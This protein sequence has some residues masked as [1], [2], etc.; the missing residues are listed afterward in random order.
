MVSLFDDS[1]FFSPIPN[2][3][4]L[5]IFQLNC[6]FVDGIDGPP[7]V[8]QGNN[9]SPPPSPP[10]SCVEKVVMVSFPLVFIFPHHSNFFS[11][12]IF[13]LNCYS[14]S[15]A[16]RPPSLIQGN[17]GSPPP[18]LPACCMDKAVMVS[19]PL[20]FIFSPPFQFF[21]SIFSVKL[22][23]SR[24]CQPPSL[25]QSREQWP[26]TTI[27]ARLSRGGSEGGF[28]FC[29]YFFPTIQILSHHFFS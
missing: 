28:S 24:P 7:S 9:G 8:Y 18:S 16:G 5:L 13:Q 17:N 14:V 22:L 10:T 15:H 20:V 4:S 19:F 26:T 3:F 6:Y 1:I 11:P 29:F 21:L 12:L 23:F 27:H 2:I 25:P